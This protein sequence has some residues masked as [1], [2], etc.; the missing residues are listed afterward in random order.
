MKR[1]NRVRDLPNGA[2]T[3]IFCPECGKFLPR[4][5]PSDLLYCRACGEP[6]ADH[7]CKKCGYPSLNIPKAEIEK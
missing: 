1:I 7:I 4:N 3:T 5:A 6:S 2:R